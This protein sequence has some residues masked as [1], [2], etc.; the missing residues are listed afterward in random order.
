MAAMSKLLMLPLVERLSP[1]H[2]NTRQWLQGVAG[3][4]KGEFWVEAQFLSKLHT[5]NGYKICLNY[6]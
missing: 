4:K 6:Y 5:N 2:R 3:N 1:Q